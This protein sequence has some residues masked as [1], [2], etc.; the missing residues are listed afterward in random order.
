MGGYSVL[1]GKSIVS[2]S[3]VVLI[4]ILT[5]PFGWTNGFYTLETPNFYIHFPAEYQEYAQEAGSAAEWAHRVLQPEFRHKLKERTHIA[6]LDSSDLPNGFA[7]P[8]LFNRIGLYPVDLVGYGYRSGMSANGGDWL[9]MLILHEYTHILHLDRNTGTARNIRS[10]FGRVPGVSNPHILQSYALMEGV[11]VWQETDKTKAGR[12]SAGF[13]DMFL[14]AINDNDLY[15]QGD[16]VLGPYGLTGWHPG[17]SHYFYGYLFVN[18]LIEQYGLDTFYRLLDYLAG[19]PMSLDKGLS[20]VYY[21]G[22]SQLWDDMIYQMRVTPPHSIADSTIWD[23]LG[24]AGHI[25]RHPVYSPDGMYIA[26]MTSGATASA[27]RIYNMLSGEDRQIVQG[28]FGD[29]ATIQWLD[30]NTLVY[31]KLNKD[32]YGALRYDLYQ[33]SLTERREQKLSYGQR[34]Y[35]VATQRNG[36]LV[37]LQRY[38]S[39]TVMGLKQGNSFSTIINEPG[40]RLGNIT[41]SPSN[42]QIAFSVTEANGYSNLYLLTLDHHGI[43][44]QALTQDKQ[45]QGNPSYSPDGR[46]LFFDANY[47]NRFNIYSWDS[48]RNQFYQVTHTQYGAFAPTISPDGNWLVAMNYTKAG[49]RLGKIKV[50]PANWTE[51]DLSK[52]LL[53]ENTDRARYLG[54]IRPYSPINSMRPRF[55]LPM[56]KGDPQLWT[57]IYTAGKDALDFHHYSASLGYGWESETVDYSFTYQRRFPLRFQPT[58]S[59]SL[60]QKSQAKS[61]Y[62]IQK[63]KLELVSFLQRK[64]TFSVLQAGVALTGGRVQVGTALDSSI[65]RSIFVSYQD[66]IGLDQCWQRRGGS[67]AFTQ[68]L[69]TVDK[70]SSIL[71]HWQ[72]NW[73][74]LDTGTLSLRTQIGRSEDPKA[75]DVGGL[76]GDFAMRGYSKVESQ[77]TS[78][79]SV[80]YEHILAPIERGWQDLPFFIQD[81]RASIFTDI[82]LL[83]RSEQSWRS[84][85]LEIGPNISLYYGNASLEPRIGV[86]KTIDNPK[87]LWYLQLGVA[88]F[89]F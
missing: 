32:E 29:E 62:W 53:P 80:Q 23:Y 8:V 42:G 18:Y 81:L 40:D 24:T 17:I 21:L 84:V 51:I 87:A 85:G 57:G 4:V 74:I 10:I 11:A 46:Y 15:L 61:D 82:A 26:Y 36:P 34:I 30:D 63:Q 56:L 50:D 39:H 43:S 2:T 28:Q 70:Y 31:S 69:N 73:G 22:F 45:S 58:L 83:S 59:L 37:Y 76:D 67:V 52:Q 65:S 35:A 77:H 12:G 86:V 55:W 54:I 66:Y 20:Q 13:Y 60:S 78:I 6:I 25:Q 68:D 33:Y 16:Q 47:D 88:S 44:R 41:I 79:L 14:K 19:Q 7:D 38:N 71:I 9:R 1:A 48:V 72:E 3:I 5:S 27:V 89:Y 75:F 49:Y 64:S